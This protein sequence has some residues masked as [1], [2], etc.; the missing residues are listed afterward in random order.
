MNAKL[1]IYAHVPRCVYLAHRDGMM[2]CLKNTRCSCPCNATVKLYT[3]PAPLA[4]QLDQR[5]KMDD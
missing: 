3:D 2:V 5:R 1:A 4:A